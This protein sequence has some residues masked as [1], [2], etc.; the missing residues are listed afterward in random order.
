MMIVILK[1]VQQLRNTELREVAYAKDPDRNVD[2]TWK[3]LSAW[4]V[5]PCFAGPEG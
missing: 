4:V 1:I 2:A 5:G 3:A